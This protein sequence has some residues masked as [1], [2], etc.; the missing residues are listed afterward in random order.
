MGLSV[1][2]FFLLRLQEFSI[3]GFIVFI[4]FGNI[5]ATASSNLFP[6]CPLPPP[7]VTRVCIC[8][9]W[10]YPTSHSDCSFDWGLAAAFLFSLVSRVSSSNDIAVSSTA[11]NLPPTLP[12]GVFIPLSRCPF[13]ARGVL[14]LLGHV[15]FQLLL[16]PSLL[17]CYPW[18][19]LASL[20]SGA[21]C[22][23]RLGS[24]PCIDLASGP[25]LPGLPVLHFLKIIALYVV[26][27]FLVL[28]QPHP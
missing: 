9:V 22:W 20:S 24:S 19:H 5:S 26:S 10:C 21:D 25:V 13:C 15:Y 11:P 1:A 7:L 2:L 23:A 4:K 17:L 3:C 8:A 18:P 14:S 16:C 28:C 12:G 27:G 6:F